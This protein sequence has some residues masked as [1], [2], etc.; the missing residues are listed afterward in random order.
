MGSAALV[1]LSLGASN[2]ASAED[3][4]WSMVTNTAG[5]GDQGFNDL[6]K[7]GVEASVEKL[8]GKELVIQ[9]ANKSQLVPNLKQ[10]IDSGSTVTTGVGF[11]IRD[12]L[13][14]VAIANPDAKFTL[15]DAVAVD[16]DKNPLPNVASV[17]FR[18]H[19]AAFLS[20][21]AAAMTTKGSRVGFIG[22][23]ETPPVVRFLSGFEAGLRYVN[24]DIQVSVAYVGSF[25]EPAKAKELA[26]GIYDLGADLI[27]DVAGGGG[28]GIFDAAKSMGDGYWVIG[29]DTCKGQFAPDNFLTSAVK[30]VSGAVVLENTKAAEGSFE[31]GAVSLGLKEGA[32]GLCQDNIDTLSADIMAKVEAATALILDGSMTVPSNEEELKSFQPAGD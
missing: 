2:P 30:D 23:I 9:S 24:P 7:I 6:A 28:R 8:G 31:G 16:K 20:G 10:A 15:I 21:I 18:E 1:A 11:G 32:V 26:L 17:T 13:T 3:Y 29:V 22:G 19:E 5:L 27:M 12:A 14:E 25:T 4:I